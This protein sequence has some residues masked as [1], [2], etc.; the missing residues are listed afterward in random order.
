MHMHPCESLN[1]LLLSKSQAFFT[2][3]K[4]EPKLPFL[5]SDGS[6]KMLCYAGGFKRQTKKEEPKLL[7]NLN[8]FDKQ[9]CC[10]ESHERRVQ[11]N[12]HKRFDLQA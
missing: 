10:A 7:L 2:N 11:K 8:E 4:E 6:D 12:V 3:K 1:K 9:A 5:K